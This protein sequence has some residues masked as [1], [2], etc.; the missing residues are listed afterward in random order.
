[1]GAV[2]RVAVGGGAPGRNRTDVAALIWLVLSLAYKASA[3]TNISYRG[4]I[5]VDDHTG[6][7]TSGE[8]W[9]SIK[10][11]FF[12]SKHVQILTGSDVKSHGLARH[13]FIA[14]ECC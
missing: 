13:F 5:V 4:V 9:R 2:F 11:G 14:K 8:Q 12:H 1:M 6:I 7:R 3:L 10:L